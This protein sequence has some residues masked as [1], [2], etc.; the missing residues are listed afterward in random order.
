MNEKIYYTLDEI[1]E[2]WEVNRRTVQRILKDGNDSYPLIA[3]KFGGNV[4]VHK[5]DLLEYEE[6]HIISGGNIQ[7][8]E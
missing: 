1:A 5:D 6:H 3:R 4:R 2:R 7:Q 8:K